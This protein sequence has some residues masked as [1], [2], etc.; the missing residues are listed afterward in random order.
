MA[1]S[2]SC[3]WS[4]LRVPRQ[5]TSSSSAWSIGIQM[6]SCWLCFFMNRDDTFIHCRTVAR[7]S[8]Q[9]RQHPS[10]GARGIPPWKKNLLSSNFILIINFILHSAK[11]LEAA[12]CYA[13]AWLWPSH[14]LGHGSQGTAK[15]GQQKSISLTPAGNGQ[16]LVEYRLASWRWWADPHLVPFLGYKSDSCFLLTSTAS[17]IRSIGQAL[18]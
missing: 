17:P 13:S 6:T 5:C 3:K 9:R 18:G 1:S 4:S 11:K 16:A 15:R 8:K 2:W 14:W 7:P 10:S 12:A